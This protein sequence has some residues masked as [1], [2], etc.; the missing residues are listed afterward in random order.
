MKVSRVSVQD[1]IVEIVQY[2]L[3]LRE[4]DDR[5]GQTLLKLHR[6]DLHPLPVL[7]VEHVLLDVSS[8]VVGL[9][10]L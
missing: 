4:I 6:E 9:S 7:G 3:D 5:G 10:L 1:Q 8:L 2:P